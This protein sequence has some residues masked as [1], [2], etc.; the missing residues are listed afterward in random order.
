LSYIKLPPEPKKR[1]KE[2]ERNK[3]NGNASLPSMQRQVLHQN[4]EKAKKKKRI[5]EKNTI[6]LRPQKRLYPSS[7][8]VSSHHITQS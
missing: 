2:T 1:K 5:G 6:K 7:V 8:F 4:K 3:Q